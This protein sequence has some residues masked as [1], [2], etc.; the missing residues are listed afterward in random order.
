MAI[1]LCINPATAKVDIQRA[2]DKIKV[3]SKDFISATI[4]ERLDMDTPLV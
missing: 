4:V 1:L 3:E 2:G